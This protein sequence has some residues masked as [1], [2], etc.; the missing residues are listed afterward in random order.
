MPAAL[1]SISNLVVTDRCNSRCNTCN[2]WRTKQNRDPSL[3]EIEH[4]FTHNRDFLREV[5]FIQITGG[6]PFLREDLPDIVAIIQK[7]LPRCMTW[8]PTNGL[9]PEKTAKLVSNILTQ[10]EAPMLGVTVSIDGIEDFH[11][12][13]RGIKGS[14]KKA[15]RT[16]D[17]LN[18]LGLKFPS[19]KR[20]VGLTLTE[21]NISQVL[22]IQDL[23]YT[24]GA[25]FSVRPVNISEHYYH[26]LGMF[27][28][29][30]SDNTNLTI[31]KVAARIK[32]RNGIQSFPTLAY[33]YGMIGFLKGERNLPCSA[34]SNSVFIDS[35]GDVYPCL[36]MN[37]KLG[38]IHSQSMKSIMASMEAKEAR[39]KIKNL[40]CP[41][42][43][44]ECE[45]FRDI[46]RDKTS[47]LKAWAWALN[48][49]S[50]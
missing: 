33:L 32:R 14:F 41:T 13:Q 39:G 28:K 24:Y 25:D 6:E 7:T 44:L 12:I 48:L 21:G 37:Q 19:L 18:R 1:K 47:F 16:L 2:I 34:A 43:W 11:D 22:S 46:K 35:V 49:S 20:S 4:F 29:V 27:R 8:I 30:N 50:L 45:V 31:K 38:N 36:T 10:T 5:D 3:D 26:N 23:A 9:Q 15:V 40:D 17:V 42:C